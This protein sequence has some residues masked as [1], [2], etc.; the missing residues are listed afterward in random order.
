MKKETIIGI[1][2]AVLL[3]AGIGYKFYE[4]KNPDS[5][6]FKTVEKADVPQSTSVFGFRC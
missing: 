2:I 3:I 1:I 6:L 5:Q 4:S